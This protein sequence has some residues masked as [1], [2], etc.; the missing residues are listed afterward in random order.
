MQGHAGV[1]DE[2]VERGVIAK[3]SRAACARFHFRRPV[4]AIMFGSQYPAL[5]SV[6]SMSSSVADTADKLLSG[7]QNPFFLL[8]SKVT[9][10]Y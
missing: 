8:L 4:D 10:R 1:P 2:F 5:A 7:V 6:E 3:P 9:V